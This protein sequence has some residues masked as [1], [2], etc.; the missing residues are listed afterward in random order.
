[1]AGAG[2]GLRLYDK[3]FATD[4]HSAYRRWWKYAGENY[5]A[6]NDTGPMSADL[7]YDPVVDEHVGHSPF[8]LIIPAWYFAPQDTEVASTA[9][10]MMA[11]MA[12]VFNE[13]PITG[14]DE[15]ERATMFLQL[16]G[17]FADEDT[18][19]RIWA[20]AEQHIEPLWDKARGEFTLG[21]KL[22]EA[23]PRGQLNARIMAGWVCTPGAW[24]KIF[25]EP[26]LSKFNEPTVEGVDFPRVSLS[27]AQWDG[28]ELSIAA[29]GQNASITGSTTTV[30]ITNINAE[31]NWSIP[32][33][34][35][36]RASL[37]REKGYLELKFIV[38]N[39]IVVVGKAS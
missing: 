13:G 16:C 3:I 23:H 26:N 6:W 17:E 12:G 31:E 20:E 28:Q 5:L 24:S 34:Y 7:Y 10:K 21:L 19:R 9:W 37:S 27:V 35:R 38:D 30:K 2:L 25:N 8:G 4:H 36:G 1:M 18:K 33:S 39:E 32:D 11:S 29:Q 14:L 22:N 15:P